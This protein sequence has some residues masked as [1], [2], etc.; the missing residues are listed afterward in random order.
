EVRKS[1]IAVRTP[2]RQLHHVED[3]SDNLRIRTEG[4]RLRHRKIERRERGQKA[5]LAIDGV[6]G[7]K[8]R[9]ER[10]STEHILSG[11]GGDPVCR[12]GLAR[13]KFPQFERSAEALDIRFEPAPERLSIHRLD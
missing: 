6:G 13:G 4:E 12:I 9:S 5:V 11:G 2:P 3:R 10:L 8:Q 7:R 1:A